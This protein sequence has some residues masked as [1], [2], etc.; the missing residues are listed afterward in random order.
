MKNK[1]YTAD[2]LDVC[3][4]VVK[5]LFKQFYPHGL[6]GEEIKEKAEKSAWIRRI[7]DL[8]VVKNGV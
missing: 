8:V 4:H 6:S 5:N 3:G 1:I 2:D 7:Y